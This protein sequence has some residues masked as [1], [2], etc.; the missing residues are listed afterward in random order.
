MH[1]FTSLKWLNL[2]WR[3]FWQLELWVSQKLKSTSFSGADGPKLL[4]KMGVLLSL[5]NSY[6]RYWLCFQIKS[7]NFKKVSRFT[8]LKLVPTHILQFL[9][10]IN[11]KYIK[12]LSRDWEI[13]CLM[14]FSSYFSLSIYSMKWNDLQHLK[15]FTRL[16]VTH[17][18]ERKNL[19]HVEHKTL[20]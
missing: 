16:C 11:N 3:E 14:R 2:D 15:Y 8:R 20:S 1:I 5:G 10:Y 13:M 7:L 9:I 4:Y 12:T 18:S 19:H 17:I 6:C